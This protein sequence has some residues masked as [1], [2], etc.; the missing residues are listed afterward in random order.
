MN[1]ERRRVRVVESYTAA[2]LDP[3]R[4]RAGEV[5]ALGK[6]DDEFPGWVWC[7]DPRGKSGW[8]PESYLEIH[9]DTGTLLHDYDA[10]E[11][12]VKENDILIVEIEESGWLLCI[13]D[14]G[15]RGWVPERNSGFF[16]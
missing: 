8:T 12:T 15:A 5:L 4:A 10:R 9:G 16:F 6:R 13:T 7:T 1:E 3:L 14:S 11:L 2:Y